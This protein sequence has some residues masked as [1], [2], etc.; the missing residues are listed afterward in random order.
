MSTLRYFEC[1]VKGNAAVNNA[2][3]EL[4]KFM[5]D[6]KP[7]GI[8][9]R[10]RSHRAREKME[11]A[12]GRQT[13]QFF[14]FYQEGCWHEVT[15]DEMPKLANIKGITKSKLPEKWMECWGREN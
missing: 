15:A 8:I 4:R 10:S 6:S 11:R 1:D 5:A 3:G 13:R 14:S 7:T 9:V 12:L 2:L